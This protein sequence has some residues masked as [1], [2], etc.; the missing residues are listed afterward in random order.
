M[1]DTAEEMRRGDI[2]ERMKN[3]IHGEHDVYIPEV[4]R[5]ACAE[6]EALRAGADT[7]A[8]PGGEVIRSM[9]FRHGEDDQQP[10]PTLP[11]EVVN[12]SA[13]EYFRPRPTCKLCGLEDGACVCAHIPPPQVTGVADTRAQPGGAKPA[14]WGRVIDGEAVTVSRTRNGANYEPLYASPPPQVTVDREALAQAVMNAQECGFGDRDE[15]GNYRK[16][17]CD[18]ES[19]SDKCSTCY[20]RKISDAILALRKPAP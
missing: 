7:R 5:L 17:F 20:C 9:E 19:L 16:M 3:Y 6:I 8:Q 12:Y 15:Q 2:V 18:D 4:L 1:T 13:T 10:Y 11:P 14:A